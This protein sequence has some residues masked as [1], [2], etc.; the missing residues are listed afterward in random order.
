[1]F[2]SPTVLFLCTFQ[3]S[4]IFRFLSCFFIILL[5]L[6]ISS[7]FF[8]FPWYFFMYLLQILLHNFFSWKMS[9][10]MPFLGRRWGGSHDPYIRKRSEILQVPRS[11]SYFSKFSTYSFHVSSYYSLHISSYFS[12]ISFIFSLSFSIFLHI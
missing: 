9:D 8:I 7:Y 6:H 3:I 1:M 11:S 2:P 5:S 4:Y 10:Q 12:H